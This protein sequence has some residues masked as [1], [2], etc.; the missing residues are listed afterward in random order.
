MGEVEAGELL[1]A[2]APTCE[3]PAVILRVLSGVGV[4]LSPVTTAHLLPVQ[5]PRELRFMRPDLRRVSPRA[6]R[7]A[8]GA[9]RGCRCWWLRSTSNV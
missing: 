2:L 6:K 1:V 8:A 7:T 4:E 5:D 3:Y 9:L